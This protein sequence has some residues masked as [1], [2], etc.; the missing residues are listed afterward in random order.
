MGAEYLY[1]LDPAGRCKWVAESKRCRDFSSLAVAPDG[2]IYGLT[3][4]EVCAFSSGGRLQ[5]HQY[6]APSARGYNMAI[7]LDPQGSA[8]INSGGAAGA[9]MALPISPLGI[10]NPYGSIREFLF[11]EYF[12]SPPAVTQD[13]VL[14]LG[15]R[16]VGKEVETEDGRI[17]AELGPLQLQARF[18]ATMVAWSYSLGEDLC[19]YP[20]V[21]GDG[22]IYV[23]L[24]DGNLCALDRN[25]NLK[26]TFNI[27]ESLERGHWTNWELVIGDGTVYVAADS[28]LYAIGETE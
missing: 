21:G 5:W 26:W 28:R 20:V 11:D 1:A 16:E 4:L 12:A 6:T 23:V 15:W 18:P 2:I 7:T 25:G 14:Y 17:T 9:R 22:T 19:S 13:G 8:Y 3:T 27:G 24:R 10:L